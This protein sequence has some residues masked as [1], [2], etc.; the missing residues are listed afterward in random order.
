MIAKIRKPYLLFMGDVT[1]PAF[2]KTGFGLR[3]WSPAD[4]V[5]QWSLPS[6]GVDLNLPAIDPAT[7]A[8][9]GARSMVIAVAPPGGLLPKHWEGS[10]VEALNAGLDLVAGLHD[11][12]KANPR[13]TEVAQM[14]GRN[15]VD[16]REPPQVIPLGTGRPRSGKRLLTV[17]TD[18]ALGKN[19]LPWPSPETL[20]PLGL[21]RHFG[22]QDRQEL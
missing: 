5:G 1:E 17:G 12:L 8:A 4:C 2:V 22:L 16:V 3:D 9:R 11:R 6:C 10:L 14:N 15:L 7:A 13:L 18:C 19:I 21:K 20:N